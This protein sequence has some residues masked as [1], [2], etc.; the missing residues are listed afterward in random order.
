MSELPYSADETV[1]T[2]YH[3]SL[4]M[5]NTAEVYRFPAVD[6]AAH[7][8]LAQNFRDRKS[9]TESPPA[10]SGRLQ[11]LQF[12]PHAFVGFACS[13]R[14]SAMP[15]AQSRG[16]LGQFRENSAAESAF[17]ACIYSMHVDMA[18]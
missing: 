13:T 8:R 7:A 16:Q 1:D 4:A 18:V 6:S 17:D 15:L 12:K 5:K 14:Y 3:H 2:G 9:T 11:Q 10:A